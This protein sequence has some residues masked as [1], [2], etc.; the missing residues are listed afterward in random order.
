LIEKVI[1]SSAL[2]K[3]ILREKGW[4]HV[5]DILRERPRTLYLAVKEVANAIW[6]R[7][8]HLKDINIKKLSKHSMIFLV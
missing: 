2:A 4:E 7:T 5:R 3:F 1:D 6:R 8:I